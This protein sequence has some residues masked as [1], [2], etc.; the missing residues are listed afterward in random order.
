MYVIGPVQWVNVALSSFGAT[1]TATN[2]YPSYSPLQAID[3]V[4]G[5]AGW[6]AYRQSLPSIRVTFNGT[7]DI[8]YARLMN[9]IGAYM[10][11]EVE[12]SFMGGSTQRVNIYLLFISIMHICKSYQNLNEF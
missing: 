4:M 3:G 9:K 7:F 8:C 12:L 1:A 5:A 6:F 11:K 10:I 2:T